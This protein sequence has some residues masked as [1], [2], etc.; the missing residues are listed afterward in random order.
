MIDGLWTDK[1]FW[2]KVVIAWILKLSDF[3]GHLLYVSLVSDKLNRTR[4]DIHLNRVVDIYH[5]A[6]LVIIKPQ[7]RYSREGGNPPQNAYNSEK[8]YLLLQNKYLY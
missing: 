6:N 2:K 8:S 3:L 7:G 1:H 4:L 5:H